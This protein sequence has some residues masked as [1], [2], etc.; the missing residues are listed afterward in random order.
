MAGTYTVKD[1][2]VFGDLRVKIFTVSNF[3]NSETLTIE[4]MRDVHCAI[5]VIG[6]ADKAI[7]IS[8]SGNVLTFATGADTYD[9][10][11]LVIG[12]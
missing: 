5:P 11:L 10:T 7:G 9:G 6:T 12:K 1:N 8:I 3:T 2:T 4:G